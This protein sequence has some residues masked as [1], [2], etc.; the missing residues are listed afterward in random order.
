MVGNVG[1]GSAF[2]VRVQ[3]MLDASAM[4]T[5]ACVDQAARIVQAGGELVRVAVPGMS[6]AMQLKELHVAWRA[7]GYDRPLVAD[8][9]FSA[10]AALEAACHVEKVRVNPGNFTGVP[11]GAGRRREY[12]MEE[13]AAG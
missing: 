5:L 1:V 10:A 2:P 11:A 3:S 7:R 4:D 12:T 13:Y 6:E 8:V 9:H